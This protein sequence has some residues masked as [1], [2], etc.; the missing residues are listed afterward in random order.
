MARFLHK[1]SRG[2]DDEFLLEVVLPGGSIT[3][4][5]RNISER[6][7]VLEGCVDRVKWSFDDSSSSRGDVPED[8]V[9][10]TIPKAYEFS[11]VDIIEKFRKGRALFR[12]PLRRPNYL[13]LHAFILY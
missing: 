9:E 2:T 6:R 11:D 4:V 7:L 13:L 10:F 12:F 5:F 1:T 8:L 3:Q